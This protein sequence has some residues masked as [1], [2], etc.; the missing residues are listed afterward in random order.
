[1]V[2][3][4]VENSD[5]EASKKDSNSNLYK[6]KRFCLTVHG[7]HNRD[8]LKLKKFFSNKLIWKD[9]D[10][11]Q[12][13]VVTAVVSKEFG[14]NKIHPHWQVY[15]ELS[16][17]VRMKGHMTKILGHENF[18]LERALGTKEK[19]VRYVFGVD[20][21]HEIGWIVFKKN[22][23]APW[24]YNPSAYK[25]WKNLKLRDWQS[26]LVPLLTKK[27]V[28]DREIYYI[29]DQ[30]GNTGKSILAKYL[31]TYHGAI[32]TGGK[33]GDM[34][35]AIARWQEITSQY[36]TI[37]I[38]DVCRSETFVDF[39]GIESIKNGLFFSGK[40][41][42]SMLCSYRLA[43]IVIFSNFPPQKDLLSA[44]RWKIGEVV[45]QKIIWQ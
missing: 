17:V 31:H 26:Q 34:K 10:A 44:D 40:Y 3:Q 35:Y 28:D 11:F 43:N 7:Q 12:D 23:K 29:F 39:A 4:N 24:D 9:N 41:E 25:F 22:V 33:S 2:T 16:E 20:K 18:H 14:K 32:I 1:M 27:N 45:D 13:Q 6:G 19:N 21:P 5:K 38:V 8:L 42:S 30:K 37:I 36:P 15:F